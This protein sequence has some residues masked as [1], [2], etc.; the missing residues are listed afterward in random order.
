MDM[1]KL[2][3]LGVALAIAFGTSACTTNDVWVKESEGFDRTEEKVNQT[4]GQLQANTRTDY[5]N[6]PIVTEKPWVSTKAISIKSKLPSQL[7][8]KVTINEPYPS[9]LAQVLGKMTQITGLA[10]TY[11]NDIVDGGKSGAVSPAAAQAIST[12][13]GMDSAMA[14][15]SPQVVDLSGLSM[16]GGSAPP[17]VKLALSYQGSVSGM[18]DAAANAMRASWRYEEHANRVVFYRYTT[19]TFRVAMVPGTT[20]NSSSITTKSGQDS[21]TGGGETTSKFGGTMSVWKAIDDSIKTMIS[22]KGSYTVSE[23]TGMVTVRDVPD[24]V[25]RVESYINN[26]NDGF[27]RQVTVDVR[28]YRIENNIEDIRGINW[29]LL[30]QSAGMNLNVLTPQLDITGLGL[31]ST[32][33]SIPDTAVGGARSWVGSE[34]FL[35]SLSKLGRT[36]LETSTSLQTVNN[37]PAPLRIG[38]KIAYLKE[39]TSTQ[40]ANVGSQVTLTPGEV[41]VGFNMQ[42]LPNVQDNGRDMLMQI[43]I[44]LSQLDSLKEFGV[45]TNKIQLPQVSS[46]DFMQR[47]WLSSGQSLI[48]S[49]YESN[50]TG[51]NKAGQVD[52]QAW[53]LGG[54]SNMSI[55]KE[56]IVIVITPVVTATK[57]R[58]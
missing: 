6:G 48:L 52:A 13:G 41:D 7:D 12:L 32:V 28:V 39:T 44:T 16:Q 22:S 33:I 20:E 10:I 11:E 40:T 23:A 58:L 27:S 31:S 47:V 4:I 51:N 55:Q 54:N 1:F 26:M 3:I 18:L 5:K 50:Q 42:I 19:K 9:P 24:V 57:N 45:G 29:N 37:Q 43:M 21:A 53:L 49:G 25:S 36:S 38:K 46:R 30:F 15:G 35:A 34:A 56:S 8:K 14:K 2:K 17:E